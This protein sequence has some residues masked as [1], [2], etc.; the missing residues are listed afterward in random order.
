ME[1]VNSISCLGAVLFQQ[2]KQA[3][4]PG[5]RS[6]LF[7][8]AQPLLE[9]SLELNIKYYGEANLE[10]ATTMTSL[11]ELL[12]EKAGVRVSSME[13]GKM[14]RRFGSARRHKAHFVAEAESM[15]SR[16][17]ATLIHTSSPQ[18]IHCSCSS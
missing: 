5:A 13:G 4:Q 8:Q 2:G 17:A 10:T 15:L 6:S 14:S 7:M 1:A 11:A 3:E 18:L 16:C 9:A 12:M